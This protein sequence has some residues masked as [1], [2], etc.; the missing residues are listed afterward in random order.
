MDRFSF[1]FLFL[2]F[3]LVSSLTQE[4]YSKE[5]IK[6][7][8]IFFS[9][10]ESTP[11]YQSFLE[12][13]RTTFP[14]YFREPCNLLI[15]YLDFGRMQDS[16]ELEH[17]VKIHNQR[18]ENAELDLIITMAPGTY[19]LLRK[20]GLRQLDSTPTVRI[21]FDPATSSYEYHPVNGNLFD[22]KLK[23]E[24]GKTMGHALDLFPE[25]ENVFV[26]S[27]TSKTDRYFQD[28][29][30]KASKAFEGKRH[31]TF[32]TGISLDSTIQVVKKL[33]ANSIVI[34]PTYL[35][36]IHNIPFSTTLALKLVF[37]QCNVPL[38]TLSDNFIKGGG[39]GGYVFC[40]EMLGKEVGRISGEMLY[41]KN[42]K[43]ITFNNG[44]L[45]QYLYDWKQLKKWGLL[46]SKKT[47]PESIF[48]DRELDFFAAYRWY[49]IGTLVFLISQTLLLLF[50]LRLN[51]RQ[52]LIA[53]NK[54]EVEKLYR[55]VLREDR[56]SK[57]A[58]MAASLS[59][60]L[61]QPLTAILYNAQA[62]VRF[63]EREQLDTRQ[64]R[65]IFNNI[66]EDD[67]RA[68]GLISSV[69]S[70]MRLESREKEPL[71]LQQIIRESLQIIGSETSQRKITVK[72]KLGKKQIRVLGDKIQLQQVIINLLFN[73]AIAL[74]D[75][76]EENKIVE[77]ALQSGLDSVTVSVQDSGAG[78]DPLLFEK[79]FHPFMTTRKNGFGIGL[80]LCK[81]IVEKHDGKI[82]V[83]NTP[84]G[85]AKFSFTL[86]IL[87]ND[88]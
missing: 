67:K 82:W 27:G 75:I 73:A 46:Q 64:A 74:E 50:L 49:I 84:G 17:I 51:R 68:A 86:K 38:F 52:K 19:E 18:F 22:I 47:P 55:V 3:L 20:S 87:K 6:T 80:A 58:E 83:E 54:E 76:A 30:N 1:K 65:E 40:Y 62:G 41:G 57:M 71:H 56:L 14:E 13:F 10:N 81:S 28:L 5:K 36:D 70:L 66:I 44:G 72:E 26:I 78:V 11:A 34:M 69:R 29:I 35:S 21:E 4:S 85:G 25:H 15:E 33:P 60:E 63:L 2:L 77:I 88:A 79:I 53:R 61:N 8:V 24:V 39:I 45:Y 31:F 48:I 43:E 37:R 12:G 9:L 32:L 16:T 42:P 59:H 23:F 7:V